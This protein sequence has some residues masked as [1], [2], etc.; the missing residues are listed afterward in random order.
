MKILVVDDNRQDLYML[1]TLLDSAGYEVETAADG[2]EA[3]AKLAERPA[4]I[5]VADILMPRMDGFQLCREM[6][7]S[8]SLKKIPFIFYTATYTDKDDE[9]FAISIGAERFV[10]KPSEPDVLLDA[11]REVG[12][13][14]ERGVAKVPKP[15]PKE[16]IIYLRGYSERLVR[17]LEDKTLELQAVNQLLRE[18]EQKYRSLIEDANDAIVFIDLDGKLDFVNPRFCEMLGYSMDESSG[19]VFDKLVS[20]GDRAKFVGAV[21]GLLKGDDQA[22]GE[23]RL[24]TK[25]GEVLERGRGPEGTQERRCPGHSPR[26]D[27]PQAGRGGTRCQP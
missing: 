12:R 5:V 18:S 27:C 26:R 11:V 24:V 4:Q 1:K 2:V 22:R 16:E 25:S 20:D 15:Q 9:S 19:L 23:Y 14:L 13:G 7:K 21:K 17:K 6:K 3:L 10:P 8:E